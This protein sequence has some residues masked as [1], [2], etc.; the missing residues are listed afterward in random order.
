[1][2]TFAS[3]IRLDAFPEGP[4]HIYSV[5]PDGARQTLYDDFVQNHF[6]ESHLWPLLGEMDYWLRE[7][8]QR[9]ILADK[10]RQERLALA[11]PT[12]R[13][14]GGISVRRNLRLYVF[15]PSPNLIVLLSGGVKSDVRTAQECPI[16]GPHFSL[17]QRICKALIG[18]LKLGSLCLNTTRNDF[19][20]K[21]RLFQYQTNES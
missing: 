3:L 8:T 20:P 17:A 14:E 1:V 19:L 2:N 18:D 15:L 9:H 6:P 12:K 21:Q 4:T 7:S 11:L 16:V 10:L 5:Q 13:N